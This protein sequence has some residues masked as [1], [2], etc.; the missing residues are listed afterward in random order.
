ML[1]K[2]TP[3]KTDSE[4]T[5]KSS[6]Y[7]CNEV[8]LCSG[9]LVC[10]VIFLLLPPKRHVLCKQITMVFIYLLIYLL[11]KVYRQLRNIFTTFVSAIINTDGCIVM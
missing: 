6:S 3:C 8:E 2:N 11:F 1:T 7:I 10:T 4:V 5:D 9:A